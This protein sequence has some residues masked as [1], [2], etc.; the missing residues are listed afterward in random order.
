MSSFN[1]LNKFMK[2]ESTAHGDE[3]EKKKYLDGNVRTKFLKIVVS[4][5]N[6]VGTTQ[7]NTSTLKLSVNCSPSNQISKFFL[8]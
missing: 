7:P 6:L 1:I 4:T 2:K 3:N 5:K 8:T